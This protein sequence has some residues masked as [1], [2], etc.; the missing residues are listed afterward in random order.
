MTLLCDVVSITADC[1]FGCWLSQPGVFHSGSGWRTP[2]FLWSIVVIKGIVV[3][4]LIS[5]IQVI[6]GLSLMSSGEKAV[7]TY[8]SRI[9]KAVG[10]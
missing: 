2:F 9:A 6:P 10:E 7:D 5:L 1:R 3:V 8:H 4:L